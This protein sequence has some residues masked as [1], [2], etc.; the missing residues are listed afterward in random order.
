MLLSPMSL[1]SIPAP[2]LRNPPKPS[3]LNSNPLLS[4]TCAL[5][6]IRQNSHP[7]F[8]IPSTLFSKSISIYPQ[9][10]LNVAHS[11]PKTPGGSIG[12]SSQDFALDLTPLESKRFA[13]IE[14]TPLRIT[15]IRD[16]PGVGVYT[17]VFTSL[18]M[19]YNIANPARL[20]H[21]PASQRHNS[22]CDAQ[23]PPR[24]SPDES[25]NESNEPFAIKVDS[26][27]SNQREQF[28]G[29][30]VS[31]S[32]HPQYAW[33][34][35]VWRTTGDRRKRQHRPIPHS[36]VRQEWQPQSASELQLRTFAHLSL[37]GARCPLQYL[38]RHGYRQPGKSHRL[39][40][41]DNG[42]RRDG[43]RI[44]GRPNKTDWKFCPH[45]THLVSGAG[46]PR[47]GP[48]FSSAHF[49]LWIVL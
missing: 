26:Q 18:I 5:F 38:Y 25:N 21:S 30:S 29:N 19:T 33:N 28:G 41:S 10:S 17:P 13:K 7:L 2:T 35:Y 37:Q 46:C 34:E 31:C 6:A 11:L 44:L 9:H 12:P 45:M 49:A 39:W 3:R 36:M 1:A 48:R 22:A 8:S 40:Q 16:T 20:R 14:P 23:S 15:L 42:L 27:G 47:P 24:R 32:V 43:G 4:A